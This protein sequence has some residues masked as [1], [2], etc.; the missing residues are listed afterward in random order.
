MGSSSITIGID[1]FVKAMFLKI[2]DFQKP[3][4]HP[5]CRDANLAAAGN[6]SRAPRTGSR[7]NRDQ[8][9]ARRQVNSSGISRSSR[10][11]RD[12]RQ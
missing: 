5:K 8:K 6:A 11:R 10:Y 1:K 7:P 2:S 3:P 4:R 9:L 12:A